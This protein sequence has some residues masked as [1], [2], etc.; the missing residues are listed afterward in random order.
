MFLFLTE[1]ELDAI[2]EKL[3][4]DEIEKQIKRT[5]LSLSLRHLCNEGTCA[6]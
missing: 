2:R 4:D 3:N 5:G 1:K 6:C